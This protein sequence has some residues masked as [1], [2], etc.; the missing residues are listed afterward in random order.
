MVQTPTTQNTFFGLDISNISK[1][2]SDLR[3]Q[4]SKRNLILEFKKSSLIY[5]EAKYTNSGVQISKINSI[6]LFS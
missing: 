1:T 3:R 2:F 6:D 4:L 5:S